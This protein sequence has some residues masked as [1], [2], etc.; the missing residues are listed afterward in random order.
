MRGAKYDLKSAKLGKSL[1][2]LVLSSHFQL[3]TSNFYHL[4]STIKFKN[5]G[6]VKNEQRKKKCRGVVGKEYKK[7]FTELRP[8]RKQRYH[9]SSTNSNN[10][11]LL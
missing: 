7:E 4:T 10:H 11:I 1:Q 9:I 5:I 8:K 3:H 6:A 2:S